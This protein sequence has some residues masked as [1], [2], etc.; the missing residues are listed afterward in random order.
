LRGGW[1]GFKLLRGRWFGRKEGPSPCKWKGKGFRGGRE[2][3]SSAKRGGTIIC[4]QERKVSVEEGGKN[5]LIYWRGGKER[6][7]SPRKV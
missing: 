5:L 6:S 3:F 4:K 1:R 2:G 7:T